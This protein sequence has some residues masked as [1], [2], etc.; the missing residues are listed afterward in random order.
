MQ[1]GLN[2]FSLCLFHSLFLPLIKVMWNINDFDEEAFFSA[3]ER[4]ILDLLNYGLIMSGPDN[5]EDSSE[6]KGVTDEN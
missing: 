4:H 6:K 5:Q 3:R 1:V 2:I